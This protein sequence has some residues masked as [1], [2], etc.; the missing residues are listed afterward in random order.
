MF[1]NSIKSIMH[2]TLDG[3]HIICIFKV[4]FFPWKFDFSPK[5]L[6]TSLNYCILIPNR[7]CKYLLLHTT[8]FFIQT[9]YILTKFHNTTKYIL[10][11]QKPFVTLW[12]TL[13]FTVKITC[14]I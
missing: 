1:L 3:L 7:N 13:F 12:S 9:I 8:F 4:R 14:F 5:Y 6:E 2:I 11:L 10:A